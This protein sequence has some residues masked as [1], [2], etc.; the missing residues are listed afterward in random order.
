LIGA[1]KRLKCDLKSL[2][3]VS[4]VSALDKENPIQTCKT[5]SYKF[6]N[7]FEAPELFGYIYF[8]DGYR[9]IP[10]KKGEG[11]PYENE[12][13][14]YNVPLRVGER[15]EVIILDDDL[16]L[17]NEVCRLDFDFDGY[18]RQEQISYYQGEIVSEVLIE[19]Y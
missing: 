1:S 5:C 14:I 13:T 12:Q 7:F 18:S 3:K 4:R 9:K 16:L 19:F 6:D 2:R 8:N 17:D 15:V 11:D 10:M